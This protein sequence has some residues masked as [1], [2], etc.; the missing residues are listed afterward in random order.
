MESSFEIVGRLISSEGS[1]MAP[2]I[3]VHDFQIIK[4]VPEDWNNIQKISYRV[5]KSHYKQGM[6]LLNFN[7]EEQRV[8]MEDGQQLLNSHMS[9]LQQ[10]HLSSL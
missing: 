1:K 9:S 5:H 4:Q 6:T 7:C 10:R 3:Q 8:C 2:V